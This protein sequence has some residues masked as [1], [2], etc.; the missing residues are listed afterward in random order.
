MKRYVT[1]T[2]IISLLAPGMASAR[3]EMQAT[4]LRYDV[5]SAISQSTDNQHVL[6]DGCQ[7]RSLSPYESKTVSLVKSGIGIEVGDIEKGKPEIVKVPVASPLPDAAHES[8]VGTI[9]FQLGSA[10]LDKKSRKEL[11]HIA[12]DLAAKGAPVKIEGYTCKIGSKQLNDRLARTRAKAVASYL[13]QKGA[14]LGMDVSGKG[15]CC[16]VSV[17]LGHN[18]R[19]TISVKLAPKVEETNKLDTPESGSTSTKGGK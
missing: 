11:D 16:Y 15:K 4:S 7:A 1:P 5:G 9:Y 17:D 8:V 14:K 12:R 2:I 18:R 19:A 3:N 10:R 6:C 13:R